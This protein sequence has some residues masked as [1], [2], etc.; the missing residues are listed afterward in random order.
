MT[1]ST[2]TNLKFSNREKLTQVRQF[3]DEYKYV[4]SAFVDVF[5]EQE[6]V[7]K[8]LEKG[9]TSPVDTWMSARAV[10]CAGRQASGIVRGTRSKQEKRKFMIDKF[11][12]EGKPRKAKKLQKIY[13]ETVVSKPNID[14]VNPELDS[15]FVEID[16]DNT[17][18][19]DGWITLTSLGDNLKLVLPFKK[20][21]HF[22]SMM[23]KGNL[24]PGI[25]LSSNS[26]T[27]M[28]DIPKKEKLTVGNILGIDIG[29]TTVLSCSDG[30]VS[31]K[32][33]DNHD[34]TSITS[35]ISRKKKGSKG[36]KRA[37]SHRENYIN[38]VV[39][40]LNLSNVKQINLENIKYLRKGNKSSRALSHW[41]YTEIFGKLES[42]CEEQGVLVRKVNP[43]YTSQRCS[44]CGWTRKSNRKGRLFKCGKCGFTFDADLNASKNI[45]LENLPA[46][47]KVQRLKRLNRIGFYWDV[48]GQEPVVPVVQKASRNIFP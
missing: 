20:T 47:G 17:T 31:Q 24:K 8:F 34:L 46:I 29:Q 6:K 35:I 11:I 48:L 19:F 32:N 25:R 3:I 41:T 13:D 30:H 1:R 45:A 7:L 16:L 23:S 10:Q 12:K 5:W 2:K 33:K 40:Q 38:W 14:L 4:V 36:F 9:V 39:N 26:V 28:F 37:T 18:S 15:R 43:T 44:V 27:F 42:Y 22:N 21:K